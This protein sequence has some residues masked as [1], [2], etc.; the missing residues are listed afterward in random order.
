MVRYDDVYRDLFIRHST[1]A[2]SFDLRRD[3]DSRAALRQ[4]DNSPPNAF[5]VKQ[6][7]SNS[8]GA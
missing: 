1:E 3:V 5:D 8:I 6:P 4:F 2:V 7:L